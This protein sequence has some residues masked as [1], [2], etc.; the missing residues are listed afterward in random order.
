MF[1]MRSLVAPD[2]CFSWHV[3]KSRFIQ[4]RND[5]GD[6]AEFSGWN[7]RDASRVT[8]IESVTE[9]DAQVACTGPRARS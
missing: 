2:S 6:I 8:A 5:R 3:P 4:K 9:C 7:I 1:M